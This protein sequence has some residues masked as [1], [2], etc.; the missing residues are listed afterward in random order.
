M[1]LGDR[2]KFYEKQPLPE[3]FIPG[4]PIILR[5]D[6]KSF[7]NFCRNLQKPYSVS[8]MNLFDK[9]TQ[10]LVNQTGA[11]IGYTQSDE[12]TLILWADKEDNYKTQVYFDGKAQKLVSVICSLATYYFN[13]K[14]ADEVPSKTGCQALFD[15]RAF[16]VPSLWEACNALIWREQDATRNSIQ[17]AARAHF[18]HKQCDN[19]NGSQLQDLLHSK[20]VNWNSYP[21]RFKRGGFFNKNGP[22]DIPI[23]TTI[24]NLPEVLFHNKEIELKK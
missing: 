23:L 5:I 13:D 24:S 15:C 19:K 21:S 8:L 22:V 3:R 18:S 6:G 7:H 17:S 9:T 4:L 20:G 10:F 2:I 1:K 12:I 16:V 11:V 14:L